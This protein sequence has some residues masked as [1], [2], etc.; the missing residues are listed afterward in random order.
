MEEKGMIEEIERNLE[1][2]VQK[3]EGIKLKASEIP[4]DKVFYHNKGSDFKRIEKC[5]D[6]RDSKVEAYCII[7]AMKEMKD[8]HSIDEKE[9]TVKIVNLPA[10]I[11]RIMT[12]IQSE[13]LY[14]IT[15][16]CEK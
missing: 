3:K 10:A 4:E 6:N 11:V 16:P 1:K 8:E 13:V 2:I 9:T 12:T 5:L 14:A 7:K 15:K